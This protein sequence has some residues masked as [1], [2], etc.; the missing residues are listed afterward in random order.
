MSSLLCSLRL[1]CNLPYSKLWVQIET[2]CAKTKCC[3]QYTIKDSCRDEKANRK[4]A[5]KRMRIRNKENIPPPQNKRERRK[6]DTQL[7]RERKQNL[8]QAHTWDT[9]NSPRKML[10]SQLLPRGTQWCIKAG[11]GTANL[12]NY[13]QQTQHTTTI[14]HSSC[15]STAVGRDRNN[16]NLHRERNLILEPLKIHRIAQK[17]AVY[18]YSITESV[19][20]VSRENITEWV[21]CGSC[22]SRASSKHSFSS[23]HL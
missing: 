21:I 12:G 2:T 14:T 8:K 22:A 10:C 4:W 16:T 23:G 13:S 20:R 11:L 17:M 6:Q 9:L 5:K 15:L 18:L 1:W 3:Q 19:S 7:K